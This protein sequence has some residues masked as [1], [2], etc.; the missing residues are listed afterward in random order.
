MRDYEKPNG[1]MVDFLKELA[2]LMDKYNVEITAS[3]EWMGYAECGSDIQIRVEND[4]T[5]QFFSIPFGASLDK[6]SIDHVIHEAT[7]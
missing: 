3:D 7:K 5:E 6:D 1:A 4:G 2:T